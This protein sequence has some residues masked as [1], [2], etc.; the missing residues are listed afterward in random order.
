M[1]DA[2]FYAGLESFG[3]FAQVTDLTLYVPAPDDWLV[4]IADI[5]GSTQAISEGRY[6]DVNLVGAACIT[7]VLNVTKGHRLPYVFG[8]DGATVMV[9]PAD[10]PAVKEALLKTQ[11]LAESGFALSLRVG[12]VPVSDLRRDGSD[13]L[14]AKF[15]LSPGN[16]LA[17][18]AGGGVARADAL[19]KNGDGTEGYVFQYDS[20]AG[21]PD[22]EGLSCRW[23]PL[24]TQRGVMLSILVHALDTDRESAARVYERVLA[25]LRREL[26][27]DPQDNRPVVAEN[28]RFRWPPR[29]LRSEA[30][31]T[32]GEQG[33]WRRRLFLTVQSLIQWY[34]EKF[35]KSA[36]GYDAPA[37]RQELRDNSD[38][39]RFDDTL[40]LILDCPAADAE[41]I[42]RVLAGIRG[43]GSI[44]YGVHRADSALMTCL[45]FNLTESEHIHFIDGGDGGFAVAAKQLKRQLAETG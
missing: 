18:F 40:R 36:G 41:T 27:Y 43:E 12:A 26:G 31:A 35:D 5:K 19:I 37:Y 7:A 17:M 1:N 8:G 23:E 29:G 11:R 39:R 38:Y 42:E 25:E 10:L 2:D 28:M 13:V 4:V 32:R 30:M 44:A 45:V 3:D 9:P 34:L 33:Y 15:R 14:V 20:D 21:N 16:Y 24:K 6:K 22:L